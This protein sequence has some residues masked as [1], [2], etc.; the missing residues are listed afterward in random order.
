MKRW[1][2][3]LFLIWAPGVVAAA[4]AIVTT[5]EHSDFTRIVVT[6]PQ[7]SEWRLGRA[8]DGYSLS[9]D[10]PGLDYDL[11]KAF[12]RIPKTRLADIA[13]VADSGDLHIVAA[14][15]CFVTAFAFRPTVI[16]IDIKAGSP[17]PNS[18]F[19][20]PLVSFAGPKPEMPVT[21][22]A[23]PTATAIA[24]DWTQRSIPQRTAPPPAQQ[25]VA[26]PQP[27]QQLAPGFRD[28][29][30]RELG[31]AATQGLVDLDTTQAMPAADKPSPVGDTPF[32]VMN[33]AGMDMRLG[34]LSSQGELL[35]LQCPPDSMTD[36]AAWGDPAAAPGQVLQSIHQGL[37]TD[38]DR[39]PEAQL[40]DGARKYLY[41]GFGGEA[42]LLLAAIPAPTAEHEA[43]SAIGLILDDSTLRDN[44]FFGAETC[45]TSAALWAV[46]ARDQLRPSEP[47]A[48]GAIFQAFAALPLHL[49][50]ILAPRL[51]ERLQQ[52][53]DQ[54]AAR[55]VRDTILRVTAEVPATLQLTEA[56]L[57]LLDNQPERA[58]E[59]L[60]KA[61]ARPGP[62]EP[63][64][65]V[66]LV[67]MS[68]QDR[69]KVDP[70]RI[71]TIEALVS[72]HRGQ[73]VV[74]DLKHALVLAFGLDGA[75]A[76][77]TTWLEQAPSAT[78]A[79]WSLMA[80]KGSDSD[81]LTYAF[82][83]PPQREPV[84]EANAL[85]I[86][87]KLSALGFPRQALAW[88]N[89]QAGDGTAQ[90]EEAR[91]LMAEAHL[92]L[93]APREALLA[94]T[95]LGASANPLRARAMR[96]LGRLDEATALLQDPASAQ[97]LAIL[98]RTEQRWE[99]VAEQESPSWSAAA[100]LAIPVPESAAQPAPITLAH[101]TAVAAAAQESADILSNLLMDTA[102]PQPAP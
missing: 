79:Y 35:Q 72:Q 33:E 77:A 32:R 75:F 27:T 97:D 12:S 26:L 90:S 73:P 25:P 102:L 45:K 58:Q 31:V 44:P 40:M 84:G 68:F 94:I 91:M 52:Q 36:L 67:E 11:G 66:A 83:P 2:L 87:R 39:V 19:E 78:E 96:A 70:G 54:D 20:V 30:A 29:V 71:A 17:P 74:E 16:V 82:A 21:V 34:N 62:D 1:L 65:L 59:A 81:T 43:L 56:R 15:P 69:S 37:V 42:R 63:E 9:V 5:G 76:Q 13:R 93:Y 80:E 98:Q 48:T 14:C 60:Q 50:Q 47:I 85:S 23:V 95:G 101:A 10:Q 99:A 18:A 28:A 55:M 38:A 57:D 86:A 61:A 88:L 7:K 100:A 4:T 3:A 89:P 8:A 46:L 41:L 64:A 53:G 6:L 92:A 51:I 24:L 49:R 22:P